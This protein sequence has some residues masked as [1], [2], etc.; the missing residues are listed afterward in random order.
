M[1][2]PDCHR[3]EHDLELTREALALAEAALAQ[4]QGTCDRLR[5]QLQR[6]QRMTGQAQTYTHE[7]WAQAYGVVIDTVYT[8]QVRYDDFPQPLPGIWPLVY[9]RATVDE[10]HRRHPRVGRQKGRG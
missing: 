1:T 7:E 9:D 8:W 5:S 10:W 6:I 3:L 2:C 4:S